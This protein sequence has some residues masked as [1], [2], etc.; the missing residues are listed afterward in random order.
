VTFLIQSSIEEKKI[1]AAC[2]WL[3]P[4]IL[5]LGRLKL[6]VLKFEASLGKYFVRPP[7]PK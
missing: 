4:V 3:M 1:T 7:S 2:G 6:G 5:A